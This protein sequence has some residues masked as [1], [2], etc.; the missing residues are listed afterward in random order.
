ML[1]QEKT[2]LDQNQSVVFIDGTPHFELTAQEIIY[3][4]ES[5]GGLIFAHMKPARSKAVKD[6]L[7]SIRPKKRSSGETIE[8]H[9]GNNL[10]LIPY[11]A[12][13]FI[14]ATG[15]YQ[16]EEMTVHAPDDAIKKFI[17]E[18]NPRLAMKI[19]GL[20]SSI[21]IIRPEKKERL[22][23]IGVIL[24]A[25]ESRENSVAAELRL[26]YLNGTPIPKDL[27]VRVVHHLSKESKQDYLTW[28]RATSAIEEINTQTGDWFIKQNYEEVERLYE[29]LAR[30]LDGYALAGAKCYEGNSEEWIPLVPFWHK[31]QI[32]AEIFSEGRLKNG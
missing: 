21:R 7:K 22:E 3:P 12:E 6:L 30:S 17:F 4:V 20:H 5:G 2:S 29:S 18:D 32:L 10:R 24:S 27:T 11:A 31:Y 9:D 25:I 28:D 14:R 1:D 15:F 19:G 16:D 13:N 23:R 26:G 8:L